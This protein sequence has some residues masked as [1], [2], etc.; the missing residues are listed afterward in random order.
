M[1]T[2]R[3]L[4]KR[5]V[6]QRLLGLAVVV[7]L[8][9]TIGVLVAGPIY[10]DASREAILSSAIRT[11]AV[12]VKNVRYSVYGNDEFPW[13][14]ADAQIRSV[15]EANLPVSGL[16]RQ[17]RGEVRLAKG[18][19]VLSTP[20]LFRDGAPD[21]LPYKGRPP[22]GPGE[23]ALPTGVAKLLGVERGDEVT[24]IGP[25][26]DERILTV[27]GTF[28]APD[29]GDPFWY[30]TQNPFPSPD[31]T[32]LPPALF[33]SDGYL[34]LAGAIGLTSEYAW[35]AY[36]DF[37]GLSYEQAL[38]VPTA[39]ERTAEELRQSNPALAN[40]RVTSG[41]AT[42]FR[43]VEQR[44]ADLRVPIFLVVFQVGAV[45][46]AV[47]AGVGSLV[48]TR[49]SFELAVLR[50]RGF[51]RSKLVGSQAVQAILAAAVAYP[52]GLLLG[53]GLA[54][55]ASNSNGPSLPGVLFPIRLNDQAELLGI[56]GA[57]LGAGAL[58]LL[59]L[60]HVRCSFH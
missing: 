9:F 60:P 46:L 56:V 29:R 36:L 38:E 2:I 6:A 1:T 13:A 45:A 14:Q 48:L 54:K 51:S 26:G 43:L 8:A 47:L 50:S 5:F 17:G 31:S 42:L 49:Q 25:T 59:S 22:I 53:M 40:L 44:V 55:L 23:A 39:V 37:S 24:A 7:T 58:V 41:L 27:V 32:E 35:D 3:F 10:A 15:A 28:G 33:G 19:T 30:G 18:D 16:V 20:I 34:D 52:L 4:L 57:L 21:H 12:T 11:A